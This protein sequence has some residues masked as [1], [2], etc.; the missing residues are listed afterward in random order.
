MKKTA[1]IIILLILFSS[2]IK[3]GSD[4]TICDDI[5]NVTAIAN[6]ISVN[7]GG[8]INLSTSNNGIDAFFEWRS[9]NFSSPLFGAT[10]TISSA[11]I[12]DRGWYYLRI[13]NS[14]CSDP[15]IDSVFVSVKL[16]QGT[17]AC[18]ISNNNINYS[19]MSNDVFGNIFKNIDATFSLLRL[20]GS[21]SGADIAIY[22]HPFWKLNN[23]PEDGIYYTTN[24]PS[25]SGD[26][27]KVYIRAIKNSIAWSSHESQTVYVSHVGGKLQVKFCNLQMGG[28]NG[29]SFTT[30]VNGN[31]LQTN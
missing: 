27:N 13:F 30:T 5:K 26:F 18:T 8:T 23:E 17:P 25:F 19:N 11:K 16:P 22:F 4:L 15:K 20:S 28:S 14:Q 10:Q 24:L 9:S 1:Y 6:P 29:T 12:S 3:I 7:I 31:I 2:C 21:S